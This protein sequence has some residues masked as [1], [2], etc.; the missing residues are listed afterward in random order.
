VRLS[1]KDC[2]GQTPLDSIWLWRSEYSFLFGPLFHSFPSFQRASEAACESDSERP[3]RANTAGPRRVVG[4]RWNIYGP[5]ASLSRTGDGQ[6]MEV[7]PKSFCPMI[8]FSTRLIWTALFEKETWKAKPPLQISGFP[9]VSWAQ[10][11]SNNLVKLLNLCQH[12]LKHEGN[13]L[14][15]IFFRKRCSIFGL[16]NSPATGVTRDHSLD[17][18]PSHKLT[19]VTQLHDSPLSLFERPNRKCRWSRLP[20]LSF[21][22]WFFFHETQLHCFDSPAFFS[23]IRCST[24]GGDRA[25]IFHIQW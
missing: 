24:R 14:Q 25:A 15:E 19:S 12:Y 8:I 23:T 16:K 1:V 21:F 9:S 10:M 13:F 20:A 4:Q 2:D 18:Y 11:S 5:S 3:R 7:S 17:M 22:T 6:K